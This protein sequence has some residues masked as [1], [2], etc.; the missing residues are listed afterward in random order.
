MLPKHKYK[1]AVIPDNEG[2]QSKSERTR[3]EHTKVLFAM[4]TSLLL[5][6]LVLIIYW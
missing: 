6:L 3:L 1:Y 2:T 5:A 4:L